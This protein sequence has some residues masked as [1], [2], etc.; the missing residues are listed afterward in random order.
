MDKKEKELVNTD[1]LKK[2]NVYNL[3]LGGFGKNYEYV[4]I[5]NIKLKKNKSWPAGKPILQKMIDD[6][7]EFGVYMT[8]AK[9]KANERLNAAK[10]KR[11]MYD[12]KEYTLIQ[13]LAISEKHITKRCLSNRLEH[14]K[15][16]VHD[17]I[18]IP[19]FKVYPY[20]GKMLTLGELRRE[21][22]IPASI[23]K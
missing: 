1:F 16:S 4:C 22:K 13:L 8:P 5:R 18:T 23:I 20:N 14:L 12:G 21:L 17:S 10:A 7:W 2:P 15:W 19:P 6:G 9:K 11:Y 3:C